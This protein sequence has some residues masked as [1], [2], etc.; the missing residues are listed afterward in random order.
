MLISGLKNSIIIRVFILVLWVFAT[1]ICLIKNCSA[2]S[3]V[4]KS[5]SCCGHEKSKDDCCKAGKC[6]NLINVEKVEFNFSKIS[7]ALNYIVTSEI[8]LIVTNVFSFF[9]AFDFLRID[10]YQSD[11]C[12]NSCLPNAPPLN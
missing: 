8:K 2:D 3:I 1:N 12:L 6:I 4:K 7:L 5:H 10:I 9:P 11:P